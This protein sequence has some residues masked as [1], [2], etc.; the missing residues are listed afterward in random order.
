MVPSRLST[1]R[2]GD[3][4]GEAL[5]RIRPLLSISASCFFNSSSSERVH[6][7][8]SLSNGSCFGN[9]LNYELD[10]SVRGHTWQL[11]REDVGVFAYHWNLVKSR[12]SDRLLIVSFAGWHGCD[13]LNLNSITAGH[14]YSFPSA[15]YMTL[16]LGHPVH[17]K[18][19]IQTLCA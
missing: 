4:Q 8:R 16:V 5:G 18:Y 15:I 10:I 13:V 3:P 19:H 12:P 2:T 7:V 14:G 1:K 17:S 6:T 9:Q 11:L